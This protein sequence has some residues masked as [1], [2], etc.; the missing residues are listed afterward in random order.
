M[1]AYML[2]RCGEFQRVL[3]LEPPVRLG[4]DEERLF[5]FQKDLVERG[6]AGAHSV[7]ELP[8]GIGGEYGETVFC[9]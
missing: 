5:R 4:E 1:L 7:V 8:G 9:L 2:R 6:D 3:A